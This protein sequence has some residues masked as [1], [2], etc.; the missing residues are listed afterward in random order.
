[1][2]GVNVCQCVVWGVCGVNVCGMNVCGVCGVTFSAHWSRMRR[3]TS[4][5]QMNC[6]H[7]GLECMCVYMY[8]C[9][10]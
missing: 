6:K 7:V 10:V 9:S 1:M 8:V 4:C 5:V 2:C 3:I